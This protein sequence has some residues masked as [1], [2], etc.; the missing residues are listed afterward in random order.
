MYQ[1]PPR[2][3]PGPPVYAASPSVRRRRILPFVLPFVLFGL[4]FF[5]GS[6]AIASEPEVEV[7]P[8]FAFVD[9]DLLLVPYERHGSRGMFQMITQDLFQVRLAAVDPGTGDVLWDTQ[10]SDQLVWEA[11][12]LAGGRDYAYLTTDSGLVVVDLADG[13]VVAEGAGIGGLGDAFAAARSAYAFDRDGRRILTMNTSGDVL[14]IPLDQATATPVDAPT[15]AAWAGRLSVDA[16]PATVPEATAV[17]AALPGQDRVVLRDLPFGILGQELVRVAAGGGW[18]PVGG[19]SFHG[20]RLVVAGAAAVGAG[21]GHVLVQHQVSV[22]DSGVVLS[23]VALANGQVTGSLTVEHT[24]VRAAVGR[25]GTTAVAT[26]QEL[27]LAYGDGRITR[28]DVGATGFFGAT[29]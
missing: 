28:V 10:L 17:E 14:A 25:D 7:L 5:G 3:V 18:Q 27:A 29:T 24:V 15:A 20:A 1:N 4:A 9:E 21:S 6:Y 12:V 2:Y 22:N 26:G 8:G 11:A 13:A 19:T 23:V 16:L